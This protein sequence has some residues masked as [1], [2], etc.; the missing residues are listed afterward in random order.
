M[1]KKSG[2]GAK[3]AKSAAKKAPAL[4]GPD[5]AGEAEG[6]SPLLH[7]PATKTTTTSRHKIIWV[8][9]TKNAAKADAKARKAAA[10]AAL[11]GATQ[12]SADPSQTAHTSPSQHIA[13]D[14]PQADKPAKPGGA[15]R[16]R[17][18]RSASS[19]SSVA[20]T[21]DKAKPKSK[22]KPSTTA[23]AGGGS[24][25]TGS[26]RYALAT[27]I[28]GPLSRISLT[29]FA[30]R[31]V[32]S[33][34][35]IRSPR[36]SAVATAYATIR[37][38]QHQNDSAKSPKLS[39]GTK[40]ARAKAKP[41]AGSRNRSAKPS[42]SSGA[43][44]RKRARKHQLLAHSEPACAQD[45]ADQDGQLQPLVLDSQ[46]SQG[47]DSQQDDHQQQQTL[48]DESDHDPDYESLLPEELRHF[49]ALTHHHHQH[50]HHQDLN[51]VPDP[52]DQDQGEPAADE[53]ITDSLVESL[54][55]EAHAVA[56]ARSLLETHHPQ[57]EPITEAAQPPLAPPPPV[58]KAIRVHPETPPPHSSPDAYQTPPS[59]EQQQQ[60][61]HHHTEPQM[62][63]MYTLDPDTV[64]MDTSPTDIP[65]TPSIARLI[66][67]PRARTGSSRP[68]SP[69]LLPSQQ[70]Q[71]QSQQ[72]QTPHDP[73]EPPPI[74]LA[75]KALAIVAAGCLASDPRP[76]ARIRGV[77]RYLRQEVKLDRIVR[78]IVQ[79]THRLSEVER[80][81][82]SAIL[83]DRMRLAVKRAERSLANQ[84]R[85]LGL[86]SKWFS[87]GYACVA[88]GC[89]VKHVLQ[90]HANILRDEQRRFE[91]LRDIETLLQGYAARTNN[92][93]SPDKD[94]VKLKGWKD[95]DLDIWFGAEIQSE[96]VEWVAA[97]H[98]PQ[99]FHTDMQCCTVVPPGHSTKVQF[100]P[101]IP[102]KINA[103]GKPSRGLVTQPL[104][105]KQAVWDFDISPTQA[106]FCWDTIMGTKV[107]HASWQWHH[108]YLLNVTPDRALI[109]TDR[110]AKY[111]RRG[112]RKVDLDRPPYSRAFG[113]TTDSTAFNCQL[114]LALRKRALERG[115][116]FDRNNL[117]P[118]WE[119]QDGVHHPATLYAQV[120]AAAA[121]TQPNARD[122]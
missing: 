26:P 97:R 90:N 112:F 34:S 72:G 98:H 22:V 67:S 63:P 33:S 106:F 116:D 2:G 77:T 91:T 36:R 110:I 74:S 20:T 13:T 95:S 86:P 51:D 88:G 94:Q 48:L 57:P 10:M 31:P 66:R 28:G 104:V 70:P 122:G 76:L 45:P 109:T 15:K 54:A 6:P 93:A 87:Q 30:Y 60:Q 53:I 7:Q 37:A 16:K 108:Q 19:S 39:A 105:P 55:Q 41:Q 119:R 49:A 8:D 79:T 114:E 14:E 23:K 18:D 29:Q 5:A 113:Y 35:P 107:C 21:T 121:A 9:E 92:L 52:V 75:E 102:W 84:L 103:T 17:K 25:G 120:V 68:H 1:S 47:L 12:P 38:N 83:D 117:P 100:I 11:C 40:S 82:R 80:S 58:A 101:Y 78:I 73:D 115:I 61:H 43:S 89:V 65:V 27:T 71:A 111:E 3:Q 42:S 46:L 118:H 69:P 32:P 59:Q 99:R 96:V 44:K 85:E 24:S 64:F 50:H 81:D 4:Q 56:F 62:L